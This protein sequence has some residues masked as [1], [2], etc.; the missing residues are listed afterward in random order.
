MFC[1]FSVIRRAAI[2]Q[3]DRLLMLEVREVDEYEGQF[4]FDFTRIYR[5]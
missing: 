1:N 4:A 3:I 2:G 5:F